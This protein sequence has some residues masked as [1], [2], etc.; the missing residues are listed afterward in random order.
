MLTVLSLGAGVQSS[1][2]AL[3]A[4][5]GEVQPMPDV[6]IFGD[7]RAEPR[8][9]YEWLDYLTPLLPFPV[10][11]VQEGQG[12]LANV[13]RPLRQGSFAALPAW[14]E[15]ENGCG[16]LHRQCTSKFKVDPINRQVRHLLG[17][18]GRPTPGGVLVSM[19]LGISLDEVYRMKLN[20]QPW[21][22]NRWPLVEARMTRADCL[23]WMERY[24]Y[25]RPPRS[26]CVCCPYHSDRE[27]RHLRDTDPEGW[28]TALSVDALVRDGVRGTKERLYLHKSLRPLVEVD[29]RTSEERGQLGLW[30]DHNEVCDSGMCFV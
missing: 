1:T 23:A 27:W 14:T 26:A 3:M 18:Y 7:T 10:Y 24:G 30:D 25:P 20:K 11:R 15:S 29:L 21:I 16:Q 22:E 17:I 13:M 19:W 12:L 6:A 5:H 4:A 9:V 28:R 8:A 2:L